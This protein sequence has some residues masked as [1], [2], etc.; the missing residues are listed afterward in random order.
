TPDLLIVTTPALL[1]EAEKLARLHRTHQQLDVLVADHISIFN[2]FSSGTPSADAIRRFA[3]MLYDRRPGKL[4]DIIL[5]GTSYVNPRGIDATFVPDI[6]TYLPTFPTEDISNQFNKAQAYSTDSFYGVMAD[7]SMSPMSS[8]MDV[9]VGRIPA[10]DSAEAS[11]YIRKVER[12]L[13]CPAKTDVRS[14]VISV[15]DRGNKSGHTLQAIEIG[16][17]IDSV[18][19]GT[20]IFRDYDQ[21]YF[22]KDNNPKIHNHLIADQLRAGVGLMTY[23]GH[24]NEVSIG[25]APLWNRRL[26]ASTPIT[27]LPFVMLATCD[28]YPFDLGRQGIGH[29]FVLNPDGGAIAAVAS[30]REVN[31]SYNQHL[32]LAVIENYFS[33]GPTSTLG[34]VFRLAYNKIKSDKS[35]EY[36]FNTLCY[37]YIGDPS[38]PVYTYTHTLTTESKS[39]TLTPLASDNRISGTVCRPDGSIDRDFNGTLIADLYA[40]VK[41]ITTQQHAS[42]DTLRTVPNDG[43]LLATVRATVTD[44]QFDFN[45]DMPVVKDPGPGFELHLAALRDDSHDLAAITLSDVTIDASLPDSP[46]LPEAPSITLFSIDGTESADG[47]A[48]DSRP[49]LHAEWLTPY[50]LSKRGVAG[51]SYIAIDGKRTSLSAIASCGSDGS[52]SLD[53]TPEPLTPGRHTATLYIADNS[54]RSAKASFRFNVVSDIRTGTL[55]ADRPVA[56]ENVPLAR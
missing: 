32:H 17:L 6:S 5:L 45:F 38:L 36:I 39:L 42:S 34:D 11:A 28:S 46:S 9:N 19:P 13:T 4:H 26:I 15:S 48:T 50:S 55:T 35:D 37:S 47:V 8:A 10:S 54:G 22:Y 44:G 40:P 41:M 3:K 2:E 56:S 7:G 20:H 21:S 27:D 33:A 49:S 25:S 18:A 16:Q 14:R 29:T 30:C 12:Y 31:M 24:G 1:G 52:G 23:C 53:F 43:Q 51:T